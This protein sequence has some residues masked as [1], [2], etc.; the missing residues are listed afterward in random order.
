MFLAVLLCA[1]GGS[2]GTSNIGTS[3]A[4]MPDEPERPG[5][6]R[7]TCHYMFGAVDERGIVIREPGDHDVGAVCADSA[8]TAHD[9]LLPDD[10][11]NAIGCHC[12]CELERDSCDQ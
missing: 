11:A 3:D 6:W 1:C 5:W 7:C 4:A 8:L 10:C 9:V 2:G 12:D